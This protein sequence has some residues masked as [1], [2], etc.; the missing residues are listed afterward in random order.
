MIDNGVYNPIVRKRTR[1][2]VGIF[3][4]TR[5]QNTPTWGGKPLQNQSVAAL[6]AVCVSQTSLRMWGAGG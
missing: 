1:A 5:G 4:Y 3:A 2:C 6:C